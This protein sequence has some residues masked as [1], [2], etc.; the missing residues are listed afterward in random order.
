MFNLI[1]ATKKLRAFL[2]KSV[3]SVALHNPLIF[4]GWGARD[5]L[6]LT[7]ASL[8]IFSRQRFWKLQL[9]FLG[10]ADALQ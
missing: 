8:A 4:G 9:V 2:I 1:V 10:L 3:L 5:A 6:C 7:P